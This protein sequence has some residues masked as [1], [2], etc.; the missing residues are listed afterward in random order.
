[1]TATPPEYVTGSVKQDPVTLAVA[2]RTLIPDSPYE[3]HAWGV[4][5]T[6]RGGHYAD[7]DEVQNWTDLS[8]PV[9]EG[10]DDTDEDK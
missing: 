6:D 8:A 7:W 2:V 5:T 1:M 3:A 4:M 9:K 10:R